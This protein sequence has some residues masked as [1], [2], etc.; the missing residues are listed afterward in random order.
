[1]YPYAP[2]ET[3]AWIQ[4]ILSGIGVIAIIGMLIYSYIKPEEDK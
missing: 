3:L 4:I 2:N 1:M